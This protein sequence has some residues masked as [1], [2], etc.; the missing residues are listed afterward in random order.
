LEGLVMLILFV[1]ALGAAAP[2][3]IDAERAFSRD[4]Q[5]KGQWTASRAYADPDA[6]MFTPQAIWAR[7][8]L[9][10]RKDPAAAVRW[11]PNASY[12]ACDGR[13]AVNTGPWTAA[14]GRQSGFF[15]T[16]WQQEEGRWHWISDGRHILKRPLA[17]R[18]SPIVRKA[19]CKGRA[20][21]PPLMATPS[22]KPGPGGV[23]PDDFGRGHSADRTLG[24][25]WRVR[26][27]GARNFRTYLWNGRGYTL[28]VSQT[29]G[30]Q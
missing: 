5:V 3:A 10:G 14:D 20:P 21:G 23:A 27:N 30:G 7:D 8:F 28:A 29:I 6:V 26:P 9:K 22:A 19:S 25:E 1:A 13:T 2:T 24:W 11:S 12:V 4:A 17:A 16:V 15:T 18:Q